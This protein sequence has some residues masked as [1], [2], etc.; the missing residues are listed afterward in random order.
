MFIGM[1]TEFGQ[2]SACVAAAKDRLSHRADALLLRDPPIDRDV[3]ENSDLDFLAIGA[4]EDFLPERLTLP[5]E[6]RIDVMW[7][8]QRDLQDLPALAVRGLIPHRILSSR[9][10]H[11]RDGTCAPALAELGRLFETPELRARR[12]A[13]LLEMGFATV[14]EIGVSWDSPAVAL[15]WLHMAHSACLAALADGLGML[16]PNVYTRPTET[17]RRVDVVL[18]RDER[19]GIG[20]AL[21]LEGDLEGMIARLRRFHGQLHARFPEPDWPEAMRQMTRWE[22]RYFAAPDELDWRI[23]IARELAAGGDLMGAMFYLRFHAYALTRLPL[24]AARAEAG[25]DENFLRPSER[26]GPEFARLCPDLA[27]DMALLLAGPDV[28]RPELDAAL[29]HLQGFRARTL[30]ALAA[31]GLRLPELPPWA[32]FVAPPSPH[33]TPKNYKEETHNAHS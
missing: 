10:V 6:R 21:R 15:F 22:Y 14:R 3:P 31:R 17:L 30:G 23:A 13:G 24:V 8:P 1:S 11:D 5:G 2:I 18:G 29:D 4:A 28:G 16:C 9:L 20:R 32:P 26:V 7:V 33:N 19:A 27:E 25:G 12:V